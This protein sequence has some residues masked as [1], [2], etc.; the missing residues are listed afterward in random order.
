VIS[1]SNN[2]VELASNQSAGSATPVLS[3]PRGNSAFFQYTYSDTAGQPIASGSSIVVTASS[4]ELNG[5]VNDIMPQS[6]R[7]AGRTREFT[8]TN[9]LLA[10]NTLIDAT[11]TINVTSPSGVISSLSFVVTLE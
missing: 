6:N 2:G 5:T 10:T 9:N 8:V 11:V 4:G 1:V 7:N 3:I